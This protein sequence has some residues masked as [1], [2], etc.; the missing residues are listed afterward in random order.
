M[1][2]DEAD[3]EQVSQL[4]L[5]M[6]YDD[7]EGFIDLGEDNTFSFTAAG[8]LQGETNRTWLSINNQ[9]VAFYHIS[10][11]MEGNSSVTTGRVPCLLNGDRVNLIIAFDEQNP[12]GYI[13]GAR[14]DYVD[15]ETDTLAKAMTKLQ[16]GDELIFLCD[17]YTYS[18]KY[19]GSYTLGDPMTVEDVMVI[20]N[21]D[22]GE[23][24]ALVTYH[25]VDL[26]GQSYWTAPI[27]E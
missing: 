4:T 6:L 7:G 9:P 19:S 3:W 13:A 22:V 8:D 23:G 27:F 10:T 5:N 24:G 20:S 12:Y 15:G 25:F 1:H 17:Y 2:L 16:S 14:Y 11:V 26:Y 18:G 21:T